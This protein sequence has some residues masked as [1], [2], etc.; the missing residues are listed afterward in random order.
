M[1][2]VYRESR[3][4]SSK[5]FSRH[6]THMFASFLLG[7]GNITKSSKFYFNGNVIKNISGTIETSPFLLFPGQ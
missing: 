6:R 5:K 3:K 1:M 2:L 4:K 7:A